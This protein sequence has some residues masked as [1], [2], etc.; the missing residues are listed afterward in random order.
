MSSYYKLHLHN[1]KLLQTSSS[2]CQAITNYIFTM[3]SYYKLHFNTMSRYYKLHYIVRDE[4]KLLGKY[5]F[6]HKVFLRAECKKGRYGRNC[7]S[8]CNTNCLNDDCNSITGNCNGCKIG[9]TGQFCNQECS[10][11][12]F[13]WKCESRCTSCLDNECDPQTGHCVG[14]PRGFIGEKCT[15]ECPGSTYG[16]NCN[17]T[18]CHCS[19]LQCNKTTGQCLNGCSF[20]YHGDYC[21]SDGSVPLVALLILVGIFIFCLIWRRRLRRNSEES[22]LKLQ[23]I[24]RRLDGYSSYPIRRNEDKPNVDLPLPDSPSP[25]EKL[26]QFGSFLVKEDATEAVNDVRM[27]PEGS[28]LPDNDVTDG[29]TSGYID[30]IAKPEVMSDDGYLVVDRQ[31]VSEE[32]YEN[33]NELV[34]KLPVAVGEEIYQNSEIMNTDIERH[35]SQPLYENF[36]FLK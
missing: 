20:G 31:P 3:S 2:Q 18:C 30:V 19:G 34:V 23:R 7:A 6:G 25:P 13:G 5:I 8:E 11:G 14:C 15:I 10:S 17:N 27:E 12:T 16:M 9:F 32:N 24:E 35:E 4:M 26:R 21:E 33:V 36:G 28:Q 29:R 22:I 1:V